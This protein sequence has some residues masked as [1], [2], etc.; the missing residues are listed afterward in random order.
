[1]KIIT[2]LLSV[3]IIALNSKAQQDQKAKEILDK[4][5]EN[6]RSFKSITADFSFS[7]ENEEMDIHEKNEGSIKIK[8]KK[9]VVEIPDVGV[10][11]FSDGITVWNYMK[12]GNQVT[13]SNIEDSGNE[14][15]DPA[16]VFSIYEKGFNSR[17]LGE[18]I[19]G[20]KNCYQIELL[21]D[22][23]EFEVSKIN[24]HISKSEMIIHS[25]QLYGTDGNIYGILVK[26]MDTSKDLNDAEFVFNQANFPDV[27]VIDFR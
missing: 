21:P 22:N 17:Y 6:T 27:E 12:D 23:E 7:M 25:A 13:I 26:K 3:F 8:G 19:E 15:M 16:S 1:M 10:K 9:Y 2:I 4:V 18:V 11:I 14:L 24:I 5:S 20:G